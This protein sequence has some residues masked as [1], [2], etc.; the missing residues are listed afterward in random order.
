MSQDV[1]LL[2]CGCCKFIG[3]ACKCIN[4]KYVHFCRSCFS[5]D[6]MTRSHPICCKFEPVP[7]YPA[8]VKEWQSIGGFDAWYRLRYS[9]GD[10]PPKEV[11]LI[12]ASKPAEGREATDDKYI[13]PW[14]DFVSCHIMRP[15]GI[16]YLKYLHIKRTRSSPIG[17]QWIVEGPGLLRYQEGGGVIRI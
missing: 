1:D 15:E 14:K 16:H 7:Y 8:I 17:Y 4:H 6:V 3:E 9:D 11:S 5:C 12:S 10:M 13:V 2:T